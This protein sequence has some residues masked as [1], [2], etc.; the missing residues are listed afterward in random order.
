[1][2][3]VDVPWC[4]N[5]GDVLVTELKGGQLVEATPFVDQAVQLQNFTQVELVYDEE[6]PRDAFG[7]F[8]R[9]WWRYTLPR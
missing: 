4:R 8:L 5:T 3:T 1:M 2:R 9:G 7:R 6:S